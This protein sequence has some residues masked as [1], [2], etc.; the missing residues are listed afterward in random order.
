MGTKI[1]VVRIGGFDTHNNQNQAANSIEGN[2]ND[3]LTEVSDAIEVFFNDL[4]SQELADDVVALTFS[5]FGRKAQENGSFGTDHGEIA[6]MFVFGKPINVVF[7]APMQ[8]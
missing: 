6:P 3:L 8:I 5:E 1:Y 4:D 2:H 7:Q